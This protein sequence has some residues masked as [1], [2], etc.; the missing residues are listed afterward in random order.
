MKKCPNCNAE[1]VDNAKFCSSCGKNVESEPIVDEDI[2]L[3]KKGLKDRIKV[4]KKIDQGGMASIYLGEQLALHR[5]VVI[6]LL[7]KQYSNDEKIAN[8]FLQEARIGANLKHHNIVEIIDLGILENRPYFIMEYGEKGSLSDVIEKLKKENK[9]ISFRQACSYVLDVLDALQYANSKNIKAHRDIKPQNVIIRESG[10]A[11]LSDF[12]IALLSSETPKKGEIIGSLPYMSPEQITGDE[13][14]DHRTDIYSCGIMLHQLI[15]GELPFQGKDTTTWLTQHKTQPIPRL[16]DKLSPQD[17]QQLKSSVIDIDKL[18]KIID[19]ATKKEKADR[20][21]NMTGM[22]QALKKLLKKRESLRSPENV[23]NRRIIYILILATV[24]IISAASYYFFSNEL[25]SSCT[26]CCL[27]GDCHKGKGIFKYK[28]GET[29]S[30]EF[31]NNQP[32]GVGKYYFLNGDIYEGDFANGKINGYGTY[33]SNQQNSRYIGFFKNGKQEGN[34]TFY[35]SSGARFEGVF[36]NGEPIK[37]G[38][39]YSSEGDRY[40]GKLKDMLPN[41]YG[42]LHYK[43]KTDIYEGEFLNGMRHGK[44]KLRRKGKKTIQGVWSYDKLKKNKD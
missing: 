34:G 11:F 8:K 15:T 38:T 18:Q 26:N 43:N 32:E 31:L 37:N 12:G 4:L 19:K 36:K 9:N 17:L 6:K 41:G 20:Y 10:V 23:R 7:F 44:G 27:E 13:E 28:N 3:L 30:G 39:F 16:K 29:Y 14:L 33:I 21:Q 24:F 40:E 42:I 35:F 1:Q 5:L 2:E 22:I 25:L